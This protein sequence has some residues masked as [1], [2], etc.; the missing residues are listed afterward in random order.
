[1]HLPPMPMTPTEEQKRQMKNNK[2]EQKTAPQE[3]V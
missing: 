1:V 2:K 3:Y